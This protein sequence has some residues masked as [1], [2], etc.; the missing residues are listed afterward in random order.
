MNGIR[1]E[2]SVIIA[3]YNRAE[4]LNNALES[5]CN[6]TLDKKMY[7]IIVID[8]NSTDD[9]R[10][11]VNKF[12]RYGNIRYYLENRQGVSHARN[13]G[14]GYSRGDYLAFMDDDARANP[15]W[16]ET[17]ITCFKNIRPSPAG[18]GGPIYPFFVSPRPKWFKEEYEIR[19]GGAAPRFLMRGESFSGSNMI[20][21]KEF[22]YEYGSF[23]AKLGPIGNRFALGEETEL[24]DRAWRAGAENSFFYS[25]KL[26]MFHVVPRHKMTVSYK[27]K[28]NFASGQAIYL[29]QTEKTFYYRLKSILS[30][31][32]SIIRSFG[33][34][35]FLQKKKHDT[36]QN[37][38]IENFSCIMVKL[39]FMAGCLGINIHLRQR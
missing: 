35:F 25:P 18:A 21:R 26:I 22:F 36:Y 29:K 9:T 14:C 31:L 32:V 27:F 20:F 19:S 1:M 30:G 17:A 2:I 6:Q 39:G 15:D 12:L 34:T 24:F 7:E 11:V 5:L 37:W 4:M 23:N 8:N 3:T 38:L 16:L 13:S 10:S 33:Y 28:R